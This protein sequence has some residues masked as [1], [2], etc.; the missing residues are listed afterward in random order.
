M[1]ATEREDEQVF[2]AS[3]RWEYNLPVPLVGKR[4]ESAMSKPQEQWA[5]HL[6]SKLNAAWEADALP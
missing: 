4:V 3:A 6:L 5:E 1:R 2:R